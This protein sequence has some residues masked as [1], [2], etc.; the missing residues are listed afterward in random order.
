MVSSTSARARERLVF[1]GSFVVPNRVE[2]A[3]GRLVISHGMVTAK[4]L[5]E[6]EQRTFSGQYAAAAGKP[7]LYITERC[8]FRSL[9]TGWS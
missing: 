3:D 5:D 9:P 1:V 4:F 6:V 7:V 8:V 2:V